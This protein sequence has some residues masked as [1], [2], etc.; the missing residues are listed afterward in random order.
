[1]KTISTRPTICFF[2]F[3]SLLF[4][5]GNIFS[6]T[7]QTLFVDIANTSG[8]EDGSTLYPFNTIQ[9]G[10]DAAVTGDTVLVHPGTYFENISIES[11]GIVLGS[12]FLIS[13]F[14]SYISNTIIDGNAIDKVVFFRY[15]GPSVI[16]GFTIQ[17]GRV[18]S[19]GG[20]GIHS[21][22]STLTIDHCVIVNNTHDL[23]ESFYS[24]GIACMGGTNTII[25]CLISGNL[26]THGVGAIV[27]RFGEVNIK[28]CLITNNTGIE[29][30]NVSNES[31]SIVNST[32][33]SNMGQFI[34]VSSNMA[35]QN[36]IVW[37]N[38]NGSFYLDYITNITYTNAHFL[39]AG[40]GNISANPFFQ[41]PD[42]G[43]YNLR[44]GSPCIDMGNPDPGFNDVD[45]SRNDMGCFGG[46]Q[47]IS[48]TYLDGPPI[49]MEVGVSPFYIA[50]D[51]GAVIT[52]RILDL[53]SSVSSVIVNVETPDENIVA[54]M[55]LYDDGEHWDGGIN[56]GYYGNFI[57]HDWVPG[58]HYYLDITATDNGSLVSEANNAAG[59]DIIP[60]PD[61]IRMAFTSAPPAIDG[62]ADDVI[63][64]NIIPKDITKLKKG[65]LE[66]P[67][68]LSAEYKAC[69]DLDSIYL[70]ISV[71]DD[72]L[73]NIYGAWNGETDKI[74]VA[75]DMNNS[76]NRNQ[77]NDDFYFTFLWPEGFNVS[78]EFNGFHY[79]LQTNSQH[80][81]YQLEVAFSLQD[82][83]YPLMD[84]LGF[85]ISVT[86][87]DGEDPATTVIGWNSSINGDWWD[88]R[89]YGVAR[90][91][92]YT[93]NM[94]AQAIKIID[95]VNFPECGNPA[96]NISVR[97]L[98]FGS[99][100]INQFDITYSVNGMAIGAPETVTLLISPKDTVEYTF[101]TT[102]DLSIT[103]YYSLYVSTLLNSGDPH[104]NHALQ[105]NRF[106]FGNDSY[107][108]WTNYSTCNGL[109]SNYTRC[110]TTDH[111]GNIW[112]G[113]PYGEVSKLDAATG[114]WTLY[115]NNSGL[116]G[117]VL[118][119][120]EDRNGNI[121][122]ALDTWG[123]G[124][125]DGTS[126]TIYDNFTHVLSLS[127]DHAGNIWL[128]SWGSG[129]AKLETVSH[130]LTIYNTANSGI[131][132]NIIWDGGIMEDADHTM[133][134]GMIGGFGD[135][136]GLSKFDGTTWSNY[137][138]SNSG[139]P[140]NGVLCSL[141]DNTGNVWLGFGWNGYGVTRFDGSSW[142]TYNTG[143]SDLISDQVY[144]LYQDQM[145]NIWFGTYS[146]LSKFDGSTWESFTMENSGLSS[147]TIYSITEDFQGSI[148]IATDNG[149]CRYTPQ[150]PHFT[151][152][153]SGN[154]M[155]HM[156]FYA[157]R[158]QL[159]GT[160]MQPG[161]EIGIFDGELCV[162]AGV[163]TEVLNGTDYLE[164]RVSRD[165]PE[166]PEIDGYITGHLATFKLWNASEE[167]ES[168]TYDI[169]YLIGN[170][171]LDAG[172]SCWYEITGTSQVEQV[173]SLA[174]GWNIFSLNVV[175]DN[176]AMLAIVQP[177]IDAG[178]LVKI[179][180]ETG[181]AIEPLPL[182]MGWN[183]NIGNWAATEGYKIRVN[184][185]TNLTVTGIPIS[186]PT[187]IDLNTGWNIIGYPAAASQ[188][189]MTVLND[190][191]VSENL[192]KVQDEA[193][194]AI[195]PMPLNMGWVNNI[196]DFEPGE[197]YKV[198]VANIS[199]LTIDPSGTGGLKSTRQVTGIP[200]HFI[201]AWNGNGYDHMN[202][203]LTLTTEEGSALQSGDEIALFDGDLCVGTVKIGNHLQNL[204]SLVVSADD[205]TT[206]EI[207]DGFTAG[208]AMTF[209][210]W[211]A[212]DNSEIRIRSVYY[213][214]GYSDVFEPLGTTVAGLNLES[215]GINTWTTSLGDN[216]PNPFRE[217][218]TIPYNLGKTA[219]VELTIYDVLGQRITTLLKATQ[220][221]GSYTIVWD[222][223]NNQQEKVKAGIY[224]CRMVAE[225]E[226]LVKTI[227]VID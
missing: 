32:I 143:N 80:D 16:K 50:A 122:V 27:A 59:I 184:Q 8:I 181:A 120:L 113:N 125:F 155:D 192:M 134:F 88:T 201:K 83:G 55:S 12:L 23:E 103:G 95:L 3:M 178:S 186:E 100:A 105:T 161:D 225:N 167:R 102:A 101:T 40:D 30:I 121:W 176:T 216:Y 193:G 202:I 52:S 205:P 182:N 194:A 104:A 46:P 218:T 37:D 25:N 226:V 22:E 84:H 213:L 62:S 139:I 114:I 11:K 54:S 126:W 136:G 38:N 142:I 163:L 56:D 31:G 110:V 133:W 162:G 48:Y 115:N 93:E 158:A 18:A 64:N 44:L 117:N 191:V 195:E 14:E 170:N 116:T 214:P 188:N 157:M 207:L 108:N 7:G 69:W 49:I 141:M 156:N 20:G 112:V 19:Y 5:F 220:E 204:Y 94:P 200:Q 165:D 21:L 96:G 77:D 4:Y 166:T 89:L 2:F 197:G 28:N 74:N 151:R 183:D 9:E 198:R 128:G 26:S 15:S 43:D 63:W 73:D 180:N 99:E 90:L 199:N 111:L 33:T 129:A 65:T 172:A 168:F 119:L 107:E 164:I 221:P 71:T 97:L 208:N 209:K 13:E 150:M 109:T 51:E 98:N 160:D 79:R 76:R 227:E 159:D 149:L 41:N 189:A 87:R 17:H 211:R 92:D 1:M 66:S 173:I 70:L 147:N 61:T 130:T 206:S 6:Q 174:N 29:A 140:S 148:L 190:L 224:F 82:L 215:N 223:A 152:I 47:G 35:V 187:D 78:R 196:G 153:W 222:G 45:G 86:D 185:N 68:D 106:V 36:C 127:E 138:T 137:N 154:G 118:D 85:D 81:G 132:G 146:G 131:A 169:T 72:S 135:T 75:F 124:K 58:N 10:I 91:M 203:Y 67:A 171:T 212:A 177:L 217:E 175:P 179:Q 60:D 144:S 123:Y 42:M 53:P 34:A 57:M 145:G 210:L 39:L 219:Q 24:G